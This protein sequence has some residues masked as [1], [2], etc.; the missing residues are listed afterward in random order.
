MERSVAT[1]ENNIV[2]V[3]VSL[4]AFTTALLNPCVNVALPSMGRD[5]NIP[6][7]TLGWINN[8]WVLATAACLVPAGRVADIYGRRKLFYFGIF[9]F[10]LSCLLCSL[11]NSGAM[12]ISFRV[13]QGVSNAIVISTSVPLVTS[14]FPAAQR[15]R[16]LGIYIA[17]TLSGAGYGTVCRR[18]FNTELWL[19]EYFLSKYRS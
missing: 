6:A 2:L 14:S 13:L 8:G 5:L 12:L 17:V 16:V 11:A 3:I 15:G 19:E 4:A 9:L 18:D 7:V 1:S 10:T